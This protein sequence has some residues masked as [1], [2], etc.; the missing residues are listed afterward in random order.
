VTGEDPACPMPHPVFVV[1]GSLVTYRKP[2]HYKRHG[3]LEADEKVIA[4]TAL[5]E[6]FYKHLAGL[7]EL[8][9]IYVIENNDP[10]SV[11][12]LGVKIEGFS[13]ETG[14]GRQG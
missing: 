8:G 6:A 10:P 13:G 4:G 5:D 7:G 3:E 12:P 2:L 9:Q 14:D 1:L 11:M